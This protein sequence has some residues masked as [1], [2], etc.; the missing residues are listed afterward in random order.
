[1][2]LSATQQPELLPVSEGLRLRAYDGRPEVALGWYQDP[3]TLV[4][5][6]GK[7][8]PYDLDHVR[9]MYD[10]LS[11]RGELYWIEARGDDGA[12]RPVGD[13]TL[14]EDDLP[15]VVGEPA[16]R[17]HGIGRRVVAALVARA[18]Q[19]GW[20]EVRVEEIYDWNEGSRRCFASQGFVTCG[21]TGR[22][23]A[24]VCRL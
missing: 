18:R 14:C 23:D 24:F 7:E 9:A 13:V 10:W 1:M 15:I 12:W 22:G 17:A 4:L 20:H 8:E 16:L 6:D 19:L 21:R 2:P 5:V 11:A 3:A